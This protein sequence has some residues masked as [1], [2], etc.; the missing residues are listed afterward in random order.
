MKDF[1]YD[2]FVIYKVE[3]TRRECDLEVE[4]AW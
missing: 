4:V 2:L 1:I 3:V